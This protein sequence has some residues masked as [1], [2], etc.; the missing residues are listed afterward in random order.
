MVQ[1]VSAHQFQNCAT[2][3]VPAKVNVPAMP[4]PS[5]LY[6]HI[7]DTPA[8]PPPYRMSLSYKTSIDQAEHCPIDLSGVYRSVKCTCRSAFND[9]EWSALS[10][11]H[12]HVCISERAPA[13][14]LSNVVHGP[15][16]LFTVLSADISS[17]KTD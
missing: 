9:K 12:N 8:G 5:L 14:L 11:G 15:L 1:P 4:H 17:A 2:C 6:V 3:H 10:R 13:N 7:P 16:T